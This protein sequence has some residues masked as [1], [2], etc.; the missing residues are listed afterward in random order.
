MPHGEYGQNLFVN[1]EFEGEVRAVGYGEINV[2]EGWYPFYCDGCAAWGQGNPPDLKLGRP[3]YKPTSL[4][5]RVYT[6]P[7]AQQFFSFYRAHS[8][9]VYQIVDTIPGA[10]CRVD[11]WVQSWSSNRDVYPPVSDLDTQDGRDNST[12][13]IIVDLGG[14]ENPFSDGLPMSRGFGYDDG[15]Y[16]QYAPISFVF[17]AKNIRTSVFFQDYRRYPVKHNDAYIDS[18]SVRC[19]MPIVPT[20]IPTV[21]PT[22]TETLLPPTP[23]RIV[24]T[25]SVP[26][27]PTPTPEL[28]PIIGWYKPT[29]GALIHAE[30]RF[31]ESAAICGVTIGVTLPVYEYREVSKAELWLYVVNYGDCRGWVALRH[32]DLYGGQDGGVY[33]SN[34]A[35]SNIVFSP[36]ERK[37]LRRLLWYEVR[38]MAD[39]REAVGLDV[40]DVVANRTEIQLMSNGTIYSTLNWHDATGG[41]WQFPPGVTF[42]CWQIPD[43]AG[44]PDN[45]DLTWADEIVDAYEDGERGP[46]EGMLYYDSIPG[47]PSLCRQEGG[48]EF[49]EFHNGWGW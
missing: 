34:A 22:A 44:C 39:A 3:E 37:L 17:I 20:P 45:Y 9:G 26:N 46:C 8:A 18:A 7:S 31:P 24:P 12:W 23:T 35:A 10:V 38:G 32:P 42:E 5:D 21:T 47:G 6:E 15:I 13:R 30:P 14:G 48:L 36:D 49:M 40:L 11:A 1:P 19:R 41:V 16:D 25:A 2:F 27:T 43:N 29:V 28:G 4:A 33:S